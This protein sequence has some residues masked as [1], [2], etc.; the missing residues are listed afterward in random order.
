M[1]P[2]IVV[3]VALI[4]LLSLYSG[5]TGFLKGESEVV[6]GR[7]HRKVVV[8]SGKAGDAIAVVDL[9]GGAVSLLGAVAFWTG[10]VSFLALFLPAALLL[11]L[12]QVLAWSLHRSGRTKTTRTQTR[13]NESAGDD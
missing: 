3:L 12:R 7:R 11:V 6:L 2:I 4:G 13:E 5:I 9:F 8:F 1:E 10:Y